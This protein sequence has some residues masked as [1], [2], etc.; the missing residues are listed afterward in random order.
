MSQSQFAE[1]NDNPNTD[2]EMPQCVGSPE[3]ET[4]A[5]RDPSDNVVEM[6]ESCL[7]DGWR[8]VVDVLE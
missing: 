7:D 6:C 3:D 5:V 2:C 1:D 4:K 8:G